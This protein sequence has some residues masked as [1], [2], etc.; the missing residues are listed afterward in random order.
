[1]VKGKA[2]G[3]V[4]KLAQDSTTQMRIAREIDGGC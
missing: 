2:S 1:M 4:T 3:D